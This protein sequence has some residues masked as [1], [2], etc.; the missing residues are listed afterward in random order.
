[1]WW[2][3]AI[4][5]D[6]HSMHQQHHQQIMHQ[7]QIAAQQQQQQQI[8]NSTANNQQQLFNYKMASSFQNPATTAVSSNATSTTSSVRGYDYSMTG[9]NQAMSAPASASQW[10]Y[11]PSTIDNMHNSIHNL[12]NNMQHNMQHQQQQSTPP[13]AVS[14]SCSPPLSSR[15]LYDPPPT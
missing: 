2:Q 7:Q 6:Q 10:W 14:L 3:G 9:G 4:A 5:V 8:D 13:P 1:M 15:I 12:Q 11:P